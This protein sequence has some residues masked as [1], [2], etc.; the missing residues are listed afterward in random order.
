ME[1]MS[2]RTVYWIIRG[3]AAAVALISLALG[4]ALDLVIV[5]AF[6]A[7][8]VVASG[9]VI[10]NEVIRPRLARMPACPACGTPARDVTLGRTRFGTPHW[11]TATFYPCRHAVL[12][13]YEGRPVGQRTPGAPATM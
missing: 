10:S 4:W 5:G 3:A 1:N 13:D 7:L 12:V 11:F 6:G 2:R 8:L 9:A